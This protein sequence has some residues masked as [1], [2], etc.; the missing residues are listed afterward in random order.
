LPA[1]TG[2]PLI[3]GILRKELSLIMLLQ[4]LGVS[5][6]S[7]ALTQVQMITFSVFVVFYIPCLATLSMLKKEFGWSTTLRISIFTVGVALF[8][9]LLARGVFMLIQLMI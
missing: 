7:T 9:G 4:A 1:E 3:F 2:V 5:D 8:A 6:F